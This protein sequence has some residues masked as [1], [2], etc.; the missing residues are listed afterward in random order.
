MAD[1]HSKGDAILI[2]Q[3]K[4]P[5]RSNSDR[6]RGRQLRLAGSVLLV[7][8]GCAALLVLLRVKLHQKR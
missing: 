4:G 1:L 6:G 3:Q 7:A 2:K 5:L 8:Y